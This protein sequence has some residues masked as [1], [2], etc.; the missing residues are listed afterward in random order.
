MCVKGQNNKNNDMDQVGW[1]HLMDGNGVR[2][3]LIK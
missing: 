3:S 2:R 1:K